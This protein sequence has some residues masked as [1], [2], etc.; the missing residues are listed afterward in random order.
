[1]ILSGPA[2]STTPQ[3]QQIS[4]FNPSNNTINYSTTI[5]TSNGIGWLSPYPASGPLLPGSSSISIAADLSALPPGVQ[6]GTISFGF[7]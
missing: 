4:L 7:R 6:T 2:G 1:M 3:Q 5:S